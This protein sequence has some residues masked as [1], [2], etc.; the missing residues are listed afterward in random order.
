MLTTLPSV[1]VS[2]SSSGRVG[3]VPVSRD[4]KY[5]CIL[6]V[7]VHK[8]HGIQSCSA[9][10]NVR[11]YTETSITYFNVI[12]LSI[13]FQNFLLTNEKLHA[14][15]LPAFFRPVSLLLIPR[16]KQTLTLCVGKPSFANGLILPGAVYLGTFSFASPKFEAG[17]IRKH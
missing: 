5:A 11:T 10:D 17:T 4:S 13:S 8:C 15:T 16:F 2:F 7:V 1:H 14:P 3:I 9:Y 6:L 12:C